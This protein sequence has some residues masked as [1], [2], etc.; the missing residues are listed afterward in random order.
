MV[1]SR[2]DEIQLTFDQSRDQIIK[3]YV[4]SAAISSSELFAS[5]QLSSLNEGKSLEKVAEEN[6]KQIETYVK[7]KRDSALLPINS[8]DNI[9]SI[10]RSKQATHL[11]LYFYPAE[12]F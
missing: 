10:S 12:T 4:E 1:E 11:I 8:I 5:D 3:D 6:D 9:F 7:L 2:Q